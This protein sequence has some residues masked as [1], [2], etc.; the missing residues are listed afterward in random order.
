MKTEIYR[1]PF[2]RAL[3]LGN[4]YHVTDMLY[5][6][7]VND[8]KKFL[9]HPANYARTTAVLAAANQRQALQGQTSNTDGPSVERPVLDRSVS[10]PTPLDRSLSMLTPPSSASTNGDYW[11]NNSNTGIPLSDTNARTHSL[12]GT[13]ATTPPAP[14]YFVRASQ[15]QQPYLGSYTEPRASASSSHYGQ[16]PDMQRS[17]HHSRNP[18]MMSYQDEDMSNASSSHSIHTE[19]YVAMQP[20]SHATAQ[21]HLQPMQ[22][23]DQGRYQHQATYQPRPDGKSVFGVDGHMI[24]PANGSVSQHTEHRTN[25]ATPGHSRTHSRSHSKGSVKIF[26]T[27]NL[28]T[29]MN[30][31]IVRTPNGSPARS[32][33]RQSSRDMPNQNSQA[34]LWVQSQQQLAYNTPQQHSRG[35][36]RQ[37]SGHMPQI[38]EETPSCRMAYQLHGPGRFPDQFGRYPDDSQTYGGPNMSPV[39]PQYVVEAGASPLTGK[40]KRDRVASDPDQYIQQQQPPSN[41][42]DRQESLTPP[43]IVRREEHDES[44]KRRRSERTGMHSRSGSVY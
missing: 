18:S 34:S 21:G 16:Q 39:R 7:F 27:P 20:H 6:L 9:Y 37:M 23:H 24:V 35:H 31:R 17:Y 4:K 42:D 29:Q 26:N 44:P 8:I 10:M 36:S 11:S 43:P 22:L 32:H 25:P 3:E 2:E 12:P 1:I 30:R 40:K 19:P 28:T 5:P 15:H 41:F 33:A 13:P 14:G 38:Y